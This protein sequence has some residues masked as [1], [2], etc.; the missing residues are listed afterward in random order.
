MSTA[1]AAL[2]AHPSKER[3][4]HDACMLLSLLCHG[5]QGATKDAL[6]CRTSAAIVETLSMNLDS[7]RVQLQALPPHTRPRCSL[8]DAATL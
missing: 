7:E 6:K 5:N 3:L 1:T 4:Q 8:C 2:E